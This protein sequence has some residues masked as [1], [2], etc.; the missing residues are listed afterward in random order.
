MFLGLVLLRTNGIARSFWMFD[1]Q[2]R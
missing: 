1:D 2:I